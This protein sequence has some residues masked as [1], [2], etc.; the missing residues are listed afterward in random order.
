MRS[1]G[2]RKELES[3]FGTYNVR[4]LSFDGNDYDRLYTSETNPHNRASFTYEG[5]TK[6]SGVSTT[7]AGLWRN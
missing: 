5:D 3:V 1:I 6:K 2:L 7:R 4:T